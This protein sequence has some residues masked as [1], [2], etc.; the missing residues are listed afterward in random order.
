MA[1]REEMLAAVLAAWATARLRRGAAVPWAEIERWI[2]ADVT[3]TSAL[4]AKVRFGDL[5]RPRAQ[6]PVAWLEGL[7]AAGA[8]RVALALPDPAAESARP[9][10]VGGVP[11][12]AHQLHA[13]VGT[14]GIVLAA[15]VGPQLRSYRTRVWFPPRTTLT[16]K[17]VLEFVEN[18]E[19]AEA[20]REALLWQDQYNLHVT[21]GTDWARFVAA[22]RP[23]HDEALIRAMDMT[24]HNS[25]FHQGE[26]E[27][28]RHLARARANPGYAWQCDFLRI[29]DDDRDGDGDGAV[30][31]RTVA[32]QAAR[33]RAALVEIE[34]FAR[35]IAEPGWA[36]AFA[37]ARAILDG[38]P[39]PDRIGALADLLR[40]AGMGPD[41]LR[42]VGA[43]LQADVF[44]GMGSWN[45]RVPDDK[46][47]FHEVSSALFDE[48]LP[49]LVS[50][51]DAE[52]A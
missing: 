52:A 17:D 43:S 3:G 15:C 26:A 6:T 10:E 12:D 14:G 40:S 2:Q 41:A 34:A 5:D 50:A 39:G 27:A 19:S 33:L 46:A 4:P 13:F 37:Q 36:D 23:E 1:H 29:D 30:T 38:D 32:D 21:D 48:L 42:L 44:G 11:V 8:T 22:L 35:G 47:R 45:D 7:V 9:R 16:A 18:Q 49:S 51:V 25:R 20:L 31:A 28:W 24:A